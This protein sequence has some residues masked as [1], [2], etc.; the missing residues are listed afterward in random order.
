MNATE[1]IYKSLN[2]K[3]CLEQHVVPRHPRIHQKQSKNS[4]IKWNILVGTP[5]AICVEMQKFLEWQAIHKY[6]RV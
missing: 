2:C 5:E 1:A 3:Y 4:A 6:L